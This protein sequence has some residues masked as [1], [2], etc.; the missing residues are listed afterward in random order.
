MPVIKWTPEVVIKAA[1]DRQEVRMGQACAV[2][3]GAIKTLL[4]RGGGSHHV[5]SDPGEPPHKQSGRLY[6]SIFFSVNRKDNQVTG[7]IYSNDPKARRLELGFVGRDSLGRTYDQKPRPFMRPGL[8]NSRDRI[9]KI[10]GG[11]K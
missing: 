5:P 3:Q 1:L 8:A 2:V 7:V 6:G 11:G 10:L 4:N 9:K